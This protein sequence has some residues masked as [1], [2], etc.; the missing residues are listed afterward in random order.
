MIFLTL[1][2]VLKALRIRETIDFLPYRAW[3]DLVHNVFSI[4]ADVVKRSYIMLRASSRRHSFGGNTVLGKMCVITL[5]LTILPREHLRHK[6]N[7]VTNSSCTRG[8]KMRRFRINYFIAESVFK[9]RCFRSSWSLSC[10]KMQRSF[11]TTSLP[12]IPIKK[13]L[14]SFLIQAK[15]HEKMVDRSKRKAKRS[16]TLDR[17]LPLRPSAV[18]IN[19]RNTQKQTAKR[20]PQGNNC[21]S[22]TTTI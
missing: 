2:Y 14:N 13:K 18:L 17:S 11:S 22:A 15:A 9:I 1:F 7:K 10:E 6:P 21:S 4:F 20:C 12:Q 8:H 5:T 16:L 19:D 3:A